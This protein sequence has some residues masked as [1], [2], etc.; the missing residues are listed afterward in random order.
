M[1]VNQSTSRLGHLQMEAALRLLRGVTEALRGVRVYPFHH[2]HSI[3]QSHHQSG[4]SGGVV[5]C[6]SSGVHFDG[7]IFGETNDTPTIF[8]RGSQSITVNLTQTFHLD[9]P[10]LCGDLDVVALPG[11]HPG[12]QNVLNKTMGNGMAGNGDGRDGSDDGNGGGGGRVDAVNPD[13]GSHHPN[14]HDHDPDV[15]PHDKKRHL[16]TEC[17]HHE[18]P[19]KRRPTHVDEHT[20]G[21][22]VENSHVGAEEPEES[23]FSDSDTIEMMGTEPTPLSSS[24]MVQHCIH[25]EINQLAS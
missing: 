16:E 12:L 1:G 25:D 7:C 3:T 19:T 2:D 11:L 22:M 9:N 5:E 17:A 20:H 18:H 10:I 6:P 15:R 8:N 13:H 24:S 4:Q 21:S 23:L 14:R